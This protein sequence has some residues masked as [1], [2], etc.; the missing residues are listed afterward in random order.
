MAKRSAAEDLKFYV[1][2]WFWVPGVHLRPEVKEA[3]LKP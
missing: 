2:I 3:F 1:T